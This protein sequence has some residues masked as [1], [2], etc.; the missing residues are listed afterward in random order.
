M[1]GGLTY[2][3]SDNLHSAAGSISVWAYLPESYPINSINRH[4]IFAASANPTDPTEGYAGTLA[5]RRDQAGPDG[6]PHWNFWTTPQTG[7]ADRHDLFAPDTLAPGWHHF[8]VTWDAAQRTKALY[9]DGHL[10]ATS[11]TVTLPQDVGALLQLG[12]F[13]TGS[14]QSGMLFDDLAIFGRVLHQDEVSALAQ[15][16]TPLTVSATIVQSRTL[17]LDTNANDADSGISSV[18]LGRNGTFLDPQPY[19]DAYTWRL[20]AYEGTHVVEVRYLDQ[21]GNQSTVTQTVSVNLLAPQGSATFDSISELTA[22]LTISATDAHPPIMLQVGT[23]PTFANAEWLPLQANLEWT[24]QPPLTDVQETI[25][26]LYV[27]FQDA[28]GL[29]SSPVLVTAPA[30][31]IFLPLLVHSSSD[32]ATVAPATTQSTSLF[33][34]VIEK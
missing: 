15:A 30:R 7:D 33:L 25:P 27:R 16:T 12:R 32:A 23:D 1:W 28:A 5:L 3:I 22:T 20:P 4:Y 10:V 14:R 29:I 17:L 8:A 13:T 31:R 6:T 24:W 9:L 21:A 2:P 18:Q 19:H 11:D 26:P 34:P